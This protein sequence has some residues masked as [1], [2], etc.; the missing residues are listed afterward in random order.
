MICVGMETITAWAG[1]LERQSKELSLQGQPRTAREM[2]ATLKCIEA[3]VTAFLIKF[4]MREKEESDG[5]E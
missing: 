4:E 2:L 5:E 3:A 1:K